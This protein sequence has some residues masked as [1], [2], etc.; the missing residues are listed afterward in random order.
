MSDSFEVITQSLL[1]AS[2]GVNDLLDDVR[3]HDVSELACGRAAVG[4]DALAG[5]VTDFC[6]RWSAGVS[7]LV[8]DGQNLSK[9]LETA[10]K[11]YADQDANA[12]RLLRGQR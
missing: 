6:D 10:A 11:D 8:E 3:Q 2:G 12:A 5:T 7:Y 4:H 1:D 9:G